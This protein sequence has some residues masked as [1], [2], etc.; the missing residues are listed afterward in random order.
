MEESIVKSSK[1]NFLNGECVLIIDFCRLR[2]NDVVCTYSI[3]FLFCCGINK[4]SRVIP[5]G[6]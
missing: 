3:F 5:I 4:A 6:G 1:R 2:K